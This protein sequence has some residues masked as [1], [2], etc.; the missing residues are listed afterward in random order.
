MAGKAVENGR[1]RAL[2]SRGHD[3]H[4]ALFAIGAHSPSSAEDTFAIVPQ[5][6][7]ALIHR[8]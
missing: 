8:R 5:D 4:G 7:K 3:Q 2:A 1:Q 6:L